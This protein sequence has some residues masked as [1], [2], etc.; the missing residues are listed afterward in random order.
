MTN[1]E[2]PSAPPEASAT[3]ASPL[4]EEEWQQMFL[5]RGPLSDLAQGEGLPG[6]SAAAG[7]ATRSFAL[8]AVAFRTLEATALYEDPAG[9]DWQDHDHLVLVG[10][11]LEWYACG[12]PLESRPQVV[13][14]ALPALRE[15]HSA[16]LA[17]VAALLRPR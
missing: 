6:A 12:I 8:R 2:T 3:L 10:M 16:L 11:L 9:L 13:Q 1:G 15:H 7:E 4:T 14:R 5:R 17:R